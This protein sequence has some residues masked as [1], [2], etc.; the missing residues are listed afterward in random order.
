[1]APLHG[2]GIVAGRCALLQE[3]GALM[4]FIFKNAAELRTKV[5][6]LAKPVIKIPALLN[7]KHR[8]TLHSVIT[9]QTN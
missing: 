7:C 4:T 2:A 6:T 8:E 3:D 9:K 5:F 1:M